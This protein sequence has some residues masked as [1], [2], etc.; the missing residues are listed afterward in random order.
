[1]NFIGLDL[2]GRSVRHTSVRANYNTAPP[3]WYHKTTHY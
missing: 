1:M 2:I 3:S